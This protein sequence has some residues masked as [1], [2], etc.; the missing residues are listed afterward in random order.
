M[1]EIHL[2]IVFLPRRAICGT[3]L[4]KDKLMS[5]NGLQYIKACMKMLKNTSVYLS[6]S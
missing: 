3:F 1:G 4:V 5:L 6:I 2:F